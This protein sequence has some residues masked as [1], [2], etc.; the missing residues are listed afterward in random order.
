LHEGVVDEVIF[1]VPLSEMKK[2]ESPLMLCETLGV[3]VLILMDDQW[4]HFSRVDVGKVLDRPF[5]YLAFTPVNEVGSWAKE[6]F[7][8]VIA[9][10]VL[11]IT[12][13]LLVLIAVLVKLSSR[14]PVLFVQER[15]GLKGRRFRMYKFRAMFV[16]A[17]E[18]KSSLQAM[19]EMQGPVFKMRHDPRVTRIGFLLRRYS[20]DELPQFFNVLRGDMSLVGPRPL[21]CEE[22]ALIHGT[23]RRRFSVK[24][25]MTCIWQISGRN[26]ISYEEWMKLDLQYVDRWSLG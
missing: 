6:V 1:G 19:N 11:L 3:N 18:R 17:A 14:G 10:T 4:S 8:R 25:G 26:Q 5:V 13:P 2:Y 12:L 22:A 20:L 24:P 9:F 23:Q 15:T 16:D 21:P 7:D